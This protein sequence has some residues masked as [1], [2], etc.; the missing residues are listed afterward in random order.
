LLKKEERRALRNTIKKRLKPD[1]MIFLSMLSPRDPEHYGKGKPVE[2]EVNSFY[3][4][5]YLH[6]CTREELEKDFSFLTI[7]ELSE[8]EYFEPRS[9]NEVHHHIIWLLAGVNR[10]KSTST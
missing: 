9:N 2:N 10:H 8:H 5:R 6:F 1:G 3:D 4:Q 7:K